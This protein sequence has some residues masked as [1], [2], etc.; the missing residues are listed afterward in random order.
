MALFPKCSFEV[1]LGGGAFVPGNRVEGALLLT[2]PEPIPRVDHIQLAFQTRVWAGYGSDNNRR[3]IRNTLFDARFR[4]ELPNALLPA[5]AHRFPFFV[6]VPRWLPPGFRGPDCAIEHHI[7]TR[8]DVD[9]AI[10]PKAVVCPVIFLPPAQG[11]RATLNTRSPNGFHDTMVLEVTLASSVLALDEPIVGQI[12]LRSG[13]DA[14]FDSIELSFASLATIAMGRGDVRQG[15]SSGTFRIPASAL[16]AGEAVRFQIP[17]DP[18]FLPSFRTSFVDHDLVLAVSV[19]IPW[20][21][22][23]SFHIPLQVL[24]RGS[25]ISGDASPSVVGSERLQRLAAAM[26]QGSGLREGRAP[27]LVEG[28]VGPV[29]LRVGDAPRDAHLGVD[30]DITFPAVELG[31]VFRPLGLL[32]GFR[33][34]PLLPSAIADRHFLRCTNEDPAVGAFF[35]T[36][37]DD[38]A[39]ADEIRFSDHHLGLHFPIPN[40]EPARMVEIARVAFA[41]AQAIADAISGLPFPASLVASQPAWLAT[42]AE[43]SAFL[44]PTGPALHGVAFR[45]RVLGGEERVIVST[46][47]TIWT[48]GVPTIHVDVDLRWAP[49]PEDACAELESEAI[50]DRLRAVRAQFPVTHVH[51]Q[52]RGATLERGDWAA[53]PRALLPAIETFLAWVL[54]ARGERRADVPY[55]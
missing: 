20:G 9:W 47:R 6:D 38:L 52:G 8:L 33:A 3:V 18:L 1:L 55:R 19:D 7:E 17:S 34:S 5:G 51:A 54:D 13:H 49:L 29:A 2:A 31:I 43:Q 14:R 40:D 50:A 12:A 4:V 35:Q 22:D 53:D 16:R 26:A 23:P 39:S 21:R 11:V 36:V 15:Q 30:V 24:P 37:L 10:D 44:V 46:I 42:A 28:A 45:A 27:T 32:E 41:R 25:S 48:E